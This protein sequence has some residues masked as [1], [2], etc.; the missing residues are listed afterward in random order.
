MTVA[1]PAMSS[2]LTNQRAKSVFWNRL[3]KLSSPNCFGMSSVELRVPSGLK[4]AEA[5]NRDGDQ[6]EDDR[7]DGDDVAPADGEE[8]TLPTH[9]LISSRAAVRLKPMIETPATMTKMR[10]DTAAAKP[11]WAPPSAKASR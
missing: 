10:T 8:P 2:E 3:T 7:S 6:R 4:A 1:S 9:R 11:Y 5:V